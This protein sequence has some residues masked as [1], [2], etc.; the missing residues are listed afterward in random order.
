[1]LDVQ[2]GEVLAGGPEGADE[3]LD[4]VSG[5]DDALTLGLARVGE[6]AAAALT[7]LAGAL[8]VSPIGDR[9]SEAADKVAAG[10]IGDEHLAAL[11]GGRA[12]LFGAVHD[13]LLGRLDTALGRPRAPWDP[14][15]GTPSPGRPPA[16]QSTAADPHDGQAGSGDPRDEQA[17]SG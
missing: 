2:L 3:T 13:A 14:T 12:A 15:P 4:L 6:D 9:V 11:A 1:M 10:S 5:F 17:G 16:G 8:A 7:A